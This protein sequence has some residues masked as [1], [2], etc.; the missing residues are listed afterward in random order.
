MKIQIK[1]VF[2][3]IAEQV[4]KM[5]DVTKAKQFIT[6]FVD[7]KQIND[8]DKQL[9]V[10]NVGDCK[11]MVRLQTYLCNSLLKYEGMSLSKSVKETDK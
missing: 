3:Q 2:E 10:K 7:S 5:N 1:S 11:T 9:I 8:A 4:F 6:E